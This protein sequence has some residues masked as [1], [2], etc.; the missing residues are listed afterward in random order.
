MHETN[1]SRHR[2]G[3]NRELIVHLHNVRNK[4]GNKRNPCTCCCWLLA[5]FLLALILGV[6]FVVWSSPD[7]ICPC[8]KVCNDGLIARDDE[9]RLEVFLELAEYEIEVYNRP[10]TIAQAIKRAHEDKAQLLDFHQL[11]SNGLMSELVRKTKAEAKNI[12][13]DPAFDKYILTGAFFS[14]A[15]FP[16]LKFYNS[17]TMV[18]LTDIS[19]WCNSTELVRLFDERKRKDELMHVV[20]DFQRTGTLGCLTLMG[21]DDARTV[22]TANYT[23]KKK[24]DVGSGREFIK[25]TSSGTVHVFKQKL[26]VS[27][28]LEFLN[29]V[30]NKPIPHTIIDELANLKWD[31]FAN[32]TEPFVFWTDPSITAGDLTDSYSSMRCNSN[33]GEGPT[34]GSDLVAIKIPPPVTGN[35]PC[36]V[37]HA[38]EPWKPEIAMESVGY[39][40]PSSIPNP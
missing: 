17:S 37:F 9:K 12:F 40:L 8:G 33:D 23:V 29:T 3:K 38:K 18:P 10:L 31:E 4:Q 13:W 14:P 36:F 1:V 6:I 22:F 24:P 25:Q 7:A 28:L 26:S 34:S 21:A 20:M 11:L 32:R 35:R 2:I 39:I 16:Q 30:E 19:F 5:V 27:G 15:R